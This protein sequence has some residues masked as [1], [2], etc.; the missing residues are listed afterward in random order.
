MLR[1]PVL[2]QV[3]QR[4]ARQ[5]VFPGR[6]CGRGA[7]QGRRVSPTVQ[8][9][10]GLARF[11]RVPALQQPAVRSGQARRA[12]AQALLVGLALLAPASEQAPRA[13]PARGLPLPEVW[14]L[15]PSAQQL[16]LPVPARA[17]ARALRP[18]EPALR[19]RRPVRVQE[20][21]LVP[22]QALVL[23]R[24]LVPVRAPERPRARVRYLPAAQ[25]QPALPPPAPCGARPSA[26]RRRR[27]DR[28]RWLMQPAPRPSEGVQCFSSRASIILFGAV[29]HDGESSDLWP[30]H[31]AGRRN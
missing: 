23:A 12:L 7:R 17:L 3:L 15:A 31:G 1:H 29:E 2:R 24:A 21:P 8:P 6:V 22:A 14:A 4:R 27:K 9:Q 26:A 18:R 11:Q 5:R 30:C 28:T 19:V 25:L 16:V 10:R 20:R 13:L